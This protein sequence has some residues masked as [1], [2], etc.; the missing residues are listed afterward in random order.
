MKTSFVLFMGFTFG[1]VCFSQEEEPTFYKQIQPKHSYSIDFALPVSIANRPFKGIMQGFVRS[2]VQY[3]FSLKNCVNFGLGGNYTYF[4]INR[5]K[6]SPQM[7]GGMHLANGYI[8]LGFEKFYTERAGVD[9]GIKIGY[10]QLYFHSDALVTPNK[11]NATI[12]EPYVAFAL[13]ANQKT[14]YKWMLS[15]TFLGLGF[16]P[17]RIGD[18]VNQD[19]ETSEYS[20]ITRFL[21]FGFSYAHYFKQWD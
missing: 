9:S 10:A 4:Q 17:E 20:R 2:S 16:S 8:K 14:A 15:Y 3:Q 11:A 7:R 5:F 1:K 19:Y 21:S 6:I 12:V 13:S 18:Y